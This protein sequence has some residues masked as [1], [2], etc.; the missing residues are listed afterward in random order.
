MRNEDLLQQASSDAQRVR[1]LPSPA[2]EFLN[3][4]TDW[5]GSRMRGYEPRPESHPNPHD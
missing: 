2:R 5:N 1:D 3:R 4:E